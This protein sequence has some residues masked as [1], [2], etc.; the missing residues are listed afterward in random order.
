MTTGIMS[1]LQ[2]EI[3]LLL[4]EMKV[5]DTYT[6]GKREYIKGVFMGKEVVVVFSRWGKVASAITATELINR[7]EI[8]ELLFF[9]VAGGLNQKVNIGDIVVG[10]KLMQY[11]LDA[12]PIF[13]PFEIPLTG[14]TIL[15]AD[16]VILERLKRS[17]GQFLE[18]IDT[19][20]NSE[21]IKSFNLHAPQLYQG[22][23]LSGDQFISDQISRSAVHNK[24]PKGL[25]VEMEGAAVAQV[26]S[27][28]G[29]PFGLLRI[30][31]DT[32]DDAAPED[33][34]RFITEIASTYSLEILRFYFQAQMR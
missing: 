22:M 16:P 19:L 13:K 4:Q 33:F 6:H 10:D 18:H 34:T 24:L 3:D 15:D 32:A 27:D 2:E 1:A 30:I 11:D 5:I 12:S 9:G 17:S 29:I 26:C 28:Y 20:I 23:I 25:C 31:S 7:F 8:D 14:K 21:T